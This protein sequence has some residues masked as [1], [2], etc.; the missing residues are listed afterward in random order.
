MKKTILFFMACIFSFSDTFYAVLISTWFGLFEKCVKTMQACSQKEHFDRPLNFFSKLTSLSMMLD[1]PDLVYALSTITK[2]T[3][4]P[5]DK[6]MCFN[7]SSQSSDSTAGTSTNLISC[8][9]VSYSEI[10]FL[11]V[12]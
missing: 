4:S 2:R 10:T 6:L 11:L 8:P 3:G 9:E 1:Y 5:V 7:I 12:M